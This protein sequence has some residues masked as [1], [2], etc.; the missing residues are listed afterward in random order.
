MADLGRGRVAANGITFEYL[1]AGEGPLALCMHGFPDSPFTYR[2]LLPELARAGFH[3]VAPFVRGFAPTELP[4]LRHHVHT[5]SWSPTR[6]RW[7][8]RSAAA[9]T[10]CWWPTTGA[11]SAHGERWAGRP[12]CG[13]AR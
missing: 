6:S 7:P 11:P 13:A 10:R 12:S 1:E 5:T 3:A 9:R 2:H 4:P 8:G